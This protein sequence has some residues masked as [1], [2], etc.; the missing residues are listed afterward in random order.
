MIFPSTIIVSTNPELILEKINKLCQKLENLNSP[1][2]PDIFNIGPLSGW[3]IDKIR[4]I[5][6]FLSRKP[7]SHSNKIVLIQ[8]AQNLQTEAQNALLKNLENPGI[9]NYIFLT[10]DNSS[11]LLSTILSRCFVIKIKSSTPLTQK[12]LLNITGNIPSDLLTSEK[13]AQT[14]D[15]VLPF[16]E[17]QLTLSQKKLIKNPS[18]ENRKQI[19]KIIKAI[20][21]IKSNVD[22][23]SALDYIMLA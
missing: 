1:N 6:S 21:M 8:E 4:E 15:S 9:N 11:S 5:N 3:G 7:F 19:Q 10:T 17:E 13:F 14:K 22:P 23:K 16:L 18:T 12:K 20:Q 2:N